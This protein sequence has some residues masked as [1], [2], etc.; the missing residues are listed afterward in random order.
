MKVVLYGGGLLEG[1]YPAYVPGEDF[2]VLIFSN[3]NTDAGIGL[4]MFE[5]VAVPSKFIEDLLPHQKMIHLSTAAVYANLTG[6][7]DE[8]SE[9]TWPMNNY[10][11]AHQFFSDIVTFCNK[12]VVCLRL[13]STNVHKIHEDVLATGV[14]KRCLKNARRSILKQSDFYSAITKVLNNFVPGVYN[15]SSLDTTS[16]D[17]E[18]ALVSKYKC[19]SVYIEDS[20]VGYDFFVKNNALLQPPS[21]P[22]AQSPT[23]PLPGLPQNFPTTLLKPL[24]TNTTRL[25]RQT[26]R[27][28]T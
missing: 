4:A 6:V 16:T 18:N 24:E 27:L 9:L 15:V 26:R 23:L 10:E 12:P 19:P 25:R 3:T 20:T 2:D 11:L 17:I 22:L 28:K 1:I 21:L 13:A 7:V 14:V 5:N 8:S